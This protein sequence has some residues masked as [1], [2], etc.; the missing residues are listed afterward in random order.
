MVDS[1]LLLLLICSV[2]GLV[3]GSSKELPI[4][5]FDEGYSPLFGDA[6]LAIL[7]DGKTVH[8][9]LDERTGHVCFVVFSGYGFLILW[10]LVLC[11]ILGFW[12]CFWVLGHTGSGFIS[13][14][15]YL[16]GFFSA[17]IKLPADY[18]AGVVVAF[19]V[20]N[21]FKNLIKSL[22]QD[23]LLFF[24]TF[25]WNFFIPCSYL[26]SKLNN[27]IRPIRATWFFFFF[28]FS[29]SYVLDVFFSLSFFLSFKFWLKNMV[30]SISP[31]WLFP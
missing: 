10:R 1:C 12:Q 20:S 11:W 24:W 22:I 25:F 27:L 17:S 28:L 4:I 6:N 31:R 26:N 16:H 2:L 3:S 9:S 29:K 30:L 7:K 18:T 5:S 21:L 19:Y 15:L 14:D 23:C 8:M 13:Q